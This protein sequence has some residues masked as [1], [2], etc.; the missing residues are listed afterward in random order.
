MEKS[1]GRKRLPHNQRERQEPSDESANGTSWKKCLYSKLEAIGT[2]H[3]SESGCVGYGS[4]SLKGGRRDLDLGSQINATG[5]PHLSPVIGLNS[6]NVVTRFDPFK[7][8]KTRPSHK[9][10]E[11]AFLSHLSSVTLCTDF[12]EVVGLRPRP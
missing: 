11:R 3:Y 8:D 2:A 12:E 6:A 4:A 9:L 10:L 5:R 1:R 7:Y